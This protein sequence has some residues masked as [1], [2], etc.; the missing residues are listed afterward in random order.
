MTIHTP[1]LLRQNEARQAIR[2]RLMNPDNVRSAEVEK[3]RAA[4]KAEKDRANN[5]LAEIDAL[6]GKMLR[7]GYLIE[8]LELD[9][10]DRD[11]RILDQAERIGALLNDTDGLAGKKRAVSEIVAEVLAR[12]PGVTWDEVR[13]IRRTKPL[14]KP[15]KECMY[16]VSTQRPDL[17]LP[18]IGRI[19]GGRDH[20]TVLHSVRQIRALKEAERVK[21]AEEGACE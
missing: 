20:T 15:R 18:A 1:E 6:K 5:A 17:S 9:I 3:L 14:L 11:A 7:Q 12:F 21:M 19:F 10:A 16:E 13:G 4:L 2:A 8:H